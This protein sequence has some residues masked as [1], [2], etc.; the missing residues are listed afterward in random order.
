MDSPQGTE[1]PPDPLLPSSARGPCFPDL[2]GKGETFAEKLKRQFSGTRD[3]VRRS[4]LK[5]RGYKGQSESEMGEL[6]V[7]PHPRAIFLSPAPNLALT[8]PA[9]AHIPRSESGRVCSG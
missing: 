9:E 6:S 3:A 1:S 5:V 8:A 4:C 2:G 7:S